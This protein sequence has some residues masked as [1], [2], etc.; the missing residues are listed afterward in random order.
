VSTTGEWPNDV[1]YHSATALE[2][3]NGRF[4]IL[5]GGGNN[6]ET[7]NAV[8]VLD[9]VRMHWMRPSVSGELPIKRTSHTLTAISK[10]DPRSSKLS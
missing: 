4:V 3:F 9:S 5:F 7:F 10:E 1:I 6:S 8:H 2:D